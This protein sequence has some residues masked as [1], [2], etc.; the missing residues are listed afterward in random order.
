MTDTSNGDQSGRL[1]ANVAYFVLGFGGGALLALGI[2][3]IIVDKSN[4]MTIFNTI[5]PVIGTWV[6]TVIAFYFGRENY[7]T[8]SQQ[9]LA[10]TKQSSSTE[11]V[12]K[13]SVT[14]LM[15]P[16]K[17]MAY[18]NI[19]QGQ[20]DTNIYLSDVKAKF[21]DKYTRLPIL[22]S[23]NF[24]KYMIHVDAVNEYN[25]QSGR[26]ND[27]DTLAKFIAEGQSK[28]KEFGVNKGFV[29]VP[30]QALVE[31][32]KKQMDKITNC[33]D[34]FITDKGTDKEPLMGWIPDTKLSQY[35][36]S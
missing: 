24:P 5:L 29:V 19:P 17:D 21:T 10:A 26:P 31:D 28:N 20:D 27:K 9:T 25:S 6:G 36:Q 15:M 2:G 32:A 23:D 4:T 14:G 18:L 7:E 12:G 30:S 16:L 35:F 8:A 34:I 33:Q 13:K 1:R 22:N 11:D 3:G